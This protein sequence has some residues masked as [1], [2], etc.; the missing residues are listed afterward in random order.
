MCDFPQAFLYLSKDTTPCLC[1][2]AFPPLDLLFGPQVPRDRPDFSI[3]NL[4]N[5]G[6]YTPTHKHTCT[7]TITLSPGKPMNME[8]AVREAHTNVFAL[9]L[10]LSLSPFN[11]LFIY[12][13]LKLHHPHLHRLHFSVLI[14]PD[15]HIHK[16]GD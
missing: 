9:S 3:H 13:D 7:R 4:P 11:H 1:H 10:S 16:H 8:K 15:G 6:P 2:P 12:L 5:T 14:S